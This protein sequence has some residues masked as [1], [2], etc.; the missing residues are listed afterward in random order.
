MRLIISILASSL[1][2]LSVFSQVPS[3][4]KNPVDARLLLMQKGYSAPEVTVSKQQ[5]RFLGE[6]SHSIG[7]GAGVDFWLSPYSSKNIHWVIQ[8]TLYLQSVPI[9]YNGILPAE[10]NGFDADVNFRVLRYSSGMEANLGLVR[11]AEINDKLTLRLGISMGVQQFFINPEMFN[12]SLNVQRDGQRENINIVGNQF[13]FGGFSGLE[14]SKQELVLTPIFNV[15]IESKLKSNRH[16]IIDFRACMTEVNHIETYDF[17]LGSPGN[18]IS[19]K[20][21]IGIDI[22]YLLWLNKGLSRPSI[23]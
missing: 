19:K 13:F 9:R 18:Y 5:L 7:V 11:K 15:G 1:F 8:S 4:L 21:F 2:S 14:R 6:N 20:A 16:I 23:E 10:A 3:N 17:Q 22:G 12:V